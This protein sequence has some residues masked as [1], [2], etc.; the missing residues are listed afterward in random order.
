MLRWFPKTG[1]IFDTFM[2]DMRPPKGLAQV[3]DGTGK[4]IV[5]VGETVLLSLPSGPSCYVFDD[6]GK[7]I[8]YNILTGDGELTTKDLVIAYKADQITIEEAKTI[9]NLEK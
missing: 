2:E 5:W 9:L 7:L 1:T 4:K 3:E 8:R 6:M